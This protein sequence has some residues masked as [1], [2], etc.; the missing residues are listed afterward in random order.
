MAT[1]LFQDPS[2]LAI[3]SKKLQEFLFDSST[4]QLQ[5]SSEVGELRCV[6]LVCANSFC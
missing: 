6:K 5:S 1:W 3:G 4:A 2:T